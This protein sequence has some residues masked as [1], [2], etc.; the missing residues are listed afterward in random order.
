MKRRDIDRALKQAG[1]VITHGGSHDLATNPEKPEM[2]IS[3]PRHK[4]INEFTA[5]GILEDAGLR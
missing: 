3:L 2:K 1:W 4:E 5:K